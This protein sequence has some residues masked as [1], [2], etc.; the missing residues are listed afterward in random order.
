MEIPMAMSQ[1]QK[2]ETFRMLHER[3]G[4]LAGGD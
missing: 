2:G 4:H 3:A 1:S